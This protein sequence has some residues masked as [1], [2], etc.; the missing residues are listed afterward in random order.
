VVSI[1]LSATDASDSIVYTLASGSSLPAGLSLSTS[2]LISG[3]VPSVI[4]DS[5]YPFTVNASDG[6]NTSSRAFSIQYLNVDGSTS[7]KAFASPTQAALFGASAGNYYFKG[8]SMSAAVQLYY[9][10]SNYYDSSSYVRTFSAVYR[11]SPTVNKLGLSIPFKKIMVRRIDGDVRAVVRFN[12]SQVYNE[13]LS[14]GIVGDS[15]ENNFSSTKATR[16]ILGTAGGHGIYNLS[17]GACSWSSGISGSIGA[18]YTGVCGTYPDDLYQGY[19]SGDSGPQY[20]NTSG[21]FEH[22]LFW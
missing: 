3:N 6:I 7:Q 16:V 13:A 4:V 1:Q 9:S 10:G 18:G 15:A 11:T 2:G 8:G 5:T 20:Q 19:N 21:T 17:Q 14:Q 12:T 22:W